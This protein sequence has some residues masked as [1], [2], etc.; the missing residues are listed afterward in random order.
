VLPFF[1]A[2]ALL[3]A[4]PALAWVLWNAGRWA[5]R[6]SEPRGPVPPPHRWPASGRGLQEQ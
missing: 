6:A 3:T 1:D 2:L 5:D 4:G